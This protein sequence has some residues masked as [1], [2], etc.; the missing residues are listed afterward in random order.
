MIIVFD[1]N[2]TLLDLSALDP[3]FQSAFGD[4]GV[5]RVWFARVLQSA[6]VATIAGPYADFGAIAGDALDVVARL[7]GTDLSAT[8]KKEIL[9]GIL[10][11][12]AHPD[13][14]EGLGM[15]RDA[16]LR[17]ATLTNSTRRAVTAQLT[18]AGLTEFFEHTITVDDVRAFKP[19]VR[20]YRHAE[21]VLGA[22]PD[23]LMLVAAHDWDIAGAVAA[24]WSGAYV[25][26]PGMGAGALTPAPAVT[27]ADLV[28]VARG[29][30]A[31]R[32]AASS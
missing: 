2:E 4:A 7:R 16:G 30:L 13:V 14:T 21:G 25:A 1:V 29:I 28:E 19:D 27:G 11:L 9:Q 26:R 20:V 17:L 8:D 18:N 3:A 22:G 23:D 15:L 5:R 32:A 12:P 31:G 6:F 10:S 24:G